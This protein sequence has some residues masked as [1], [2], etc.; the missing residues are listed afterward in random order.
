MINRSV[1]WELTHRVDFS[2]IQMT[3]QCTKNLTVQGLFNLIAGLKTL[4]RVR[5]RA[6][7]CGAITWHVQTA[8]VPSLAMDLSVGK[9]YIDHSQL[10]KYNLKEYYRYNLLRLLREKSDFLIN[11]N[12]FSTLKVERC[13]QLSQ[14]G[15]S[16]R[17]MTMMRMINNFTNSDELEGCQ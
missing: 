2:L 4:N 5:Y 8:F 16:S 10:E 6:R 17:P 1:I 3:A 15:F 11:F 13:G 9:I 14:T 12:F 7:Y